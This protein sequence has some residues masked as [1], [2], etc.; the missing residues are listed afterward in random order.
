MH[1][2]AAR[3]AGIVSMGLVA[4]SALAASE[5]AYTDREQ[6]IRVVVVTG[7]H[8]YDHTE[9]YQMFDGLND[10]VWTE[11]VLPEA[12][13][14]FSP[15]KADS[16]DV[17]V[18][19]GFNQ[20]ADETMKKNLLALFESGKPL[21]ALHHSM[22]MFPEWPEAE[23]IIGARYVLK[24]EEG[25]PGSNFKHNQ[26]ISAK[27]VDP[28]HP[29]T[30]FM[31]DFVMTEETYGNV[32][33]QPDIKPL[34]TTDHPDC[35]PKIGWTKTY[36]NSDVVYLTPGHGP[37]VFRDPNYRRLV[38]QSIRWLAGT[39][40]DPSDE[41]WASLLKA[42]SF[43]GW[44]IMGKPEGFWFTDDGVLRSESHKGGFWMR[45]DKKYTNFRLRVQW[46]VGLGGNS[47]IFV[48]SQDEGYP[49]VTG[50]EVQISN[51]YR[52][53]AECTGAMY[54][55]VA[56]CPR[57]DERADMWH[58]TEVL[59]DGYRIKVWHDGI[60]IAD[61]DARKV[62]SL[63]GR[64]LTGYIGLQDSH[65]RSAYIEYRKVLVKELPMSKGGADMWTLGTQAYTF[66]KYTLFEA[67]D[68]ARALGLNFIELFPG[69]SLS[70]EHKDVRFDQNSPRELREQVKARLA[71]AGIKAVCFGVCGM[72][73]DEAECRKV[74]DFCKEMGIET[75]TCE[76]ED[77]PETWALL[78]RLTQEYGI[79][80]AIH[81]H[82]APSHYWDPAVVLEAVKDLNPRIGACADTGHWMRSGVKPLDAIRMLE[83]RIISLHLKDLPEMD[84][85]E[86]QDTIWGT[87][88]ADLP[89][90]LAE[91]DRQEFSGVF[92]IEYE[93]NWFTS[94][95]EIAECIKFF[96]DQT[97][98]LMSAPN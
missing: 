7:G 71:Q 42:N 21:L 89:A 1:T 69:Q 67:I 94:M 3:L 34:L 46:K 6:V 86:A 23:K 76:P 47:G 15:E 60:P 62:P 39:L 14:I 53:L 96:E 66:H 50:T 40:P 85:R 75:I 93:K 68:K 25:H 78:D 24:P 29:I 35:M 82:P 74:F 59:C 52:T 30:R 44:K 95:P 88:L 13:D 19:Y 10:I 18:W 65:N 9:F 43:D 91:L 64:P 33:I 83:G 79:N 41:G 58:E 84:K 48:R 54:G 37:S 32:P 73:A 36:A 8:A 81:N 56:V 49:W 22:A 20:K 97:R 51:E 63:A 17:M 26:Q 28:S 5:L 12:A 31:N 55:M 90:V 80:V 4:S 61:V 2:P 27:I 38:R 16:Y 92:S 77:K 87:G 72:N 98:R 57:P 70:P 11:A 45:T